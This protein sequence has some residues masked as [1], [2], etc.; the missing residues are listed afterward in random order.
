MWDKCM[1]DVVLRSMEKERI[2]L[3]KISTTTDNPSVNRKMGNRLKQV[4]H[5]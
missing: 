3:K 4:G 5:L 2:P 1:W